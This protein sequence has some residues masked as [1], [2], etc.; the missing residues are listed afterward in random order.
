MKAALTKGLNELLAPI[1]AEYQASKE[2][3]AVTELAY[4]VEDKKAQK[5][6]K[7]VKAI[8]PARREAAMAARAAGMAKAKEETE[9]NMIEAKDGIEKLKV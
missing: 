7:E 2:W 6:K 3:Q 9:K 4:P 8:D 5:K 1:Q